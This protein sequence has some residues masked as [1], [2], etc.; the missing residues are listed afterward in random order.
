MCHG[1]A[2]LLAERLVNDIALA[3]LCLLDP[4]RKAAYD[5]ALKARQPKVTKPNPIVP[6]GKSDPSPERSRGG[7]PGNRGKLGALVGAALVVAGV[8]GGIL[9]FGRNRPVKRQSSTPQI[10]DRPL[11]QHAIEVPLAEKQATEPKLTKVIDPETIKPIPATSKKAAIATS[12]DP[13]AEKPE[14]PA[15]HRIGAAVPEYRR[16]A[17]GEQVERAIRGGV[18]Y[19][20]QVQRPDGTWVDNADNDALSGATSLATL[21]LLAAGEKPNSSA[22]QKSLSFLRSYGPEDLRGTY[23]VSLQ[24]MVYAAA[25]PESDRARIAAN[26][27]WLERAQIKKGDK[28]LWPGSWTY[29]QVKGTRPGDNS[30]TYFALLGLNAA[31]RAGVPVKSEVWSRAS[32]YWKNTQEQDGAWT[33]SP[34]SKLS[35]AS[36]TCAG[37]LCSIIT[38]QRGGAVG[39][40]ELITKNAVRGCGTTGL[41]SGPRKG[42]DWLAIHFD[43]RENTGNGRQWQYYYLW[44]LEQ[45]AQLSGAH[46]IG[47]HDWYRLGAEELVRKQAAS[48][49]CWQGFLVEQDE[50]I[51]T[52]FALL[53]LANGRAP[54]LIHKLRHGRGND[55]NNDSNDVRNLVSTVSRDWKCGL[56]WQILDA[57]KAND[58]DFSRAPIIYMNGHEDPRVS[59]SAKRKLREYVEQGGFVFAEA[60]CGSSEFD[61]GLRKLM[62]EMFPENEHELRPLPEDHPIWK[63][64]NQLAPKSYAIS[65]V[66]HGTRTSIVYLAEDVSCFLNHAQHASSNPA[67]IR[68][69]Q[70]GENVVDYAT[71]RI[72]PPDKLS[73]RVQNRSE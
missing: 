6:V 69:I 30:C 27:A 44:G 1:N 2:R 57:E 33:Y 13:A 34:A 7:P 46:I 29:S 25:E 3:R 39:G 73:V 22:L 20:K 41:D 55:W 67:V 4:T 59:D 56:S 65:G 40:Q 64:K 10:A 11:V 51:A 43:V 36:M 5:S 62:K 12:P 16:S 47:E 31:A 71:S 35:K 63:A 38:N 14:R 18:R 17:L 53:F 32:A 8:V 58:S 66:R 28:T 23:A 60:C 61:V 19:L 42:M 45:A 26:V 72:V 21:A 49:G 70:L 48:S 68:A 24:T 54:V 15:P 50:I 37:I 9:V 52:S